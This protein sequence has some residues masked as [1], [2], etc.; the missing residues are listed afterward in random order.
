M[1]QLAK[2][3]LSHLFTND[4]AS[5]EMFIFCSLDELMDALVPGIASIDTGNISQALVTRMNWVV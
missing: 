3:Y 1:Q 5:V 2:A 4:E